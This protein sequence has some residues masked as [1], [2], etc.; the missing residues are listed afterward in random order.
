MFKKIATEYKSSSPK[1]SGITIQKAQ[2]MAA[3]GFN[4]ERENHGVVK[5]KLKLKGNILQRNS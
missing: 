3:D 4:W 2:Q 1:T 5:H